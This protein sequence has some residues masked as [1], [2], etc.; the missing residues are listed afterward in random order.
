[1]RWLVGRRR[2]SRYLKCVRDHQIECFVKQQGV[3]GG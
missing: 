3:D 2:P 1:M